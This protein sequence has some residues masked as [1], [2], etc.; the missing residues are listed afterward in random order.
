MGSIDENNIFGLLPAFVK[1]GDLYKKI[2]PGAPNGWPFQK[3]NR[4]IADLRY[5]GKDIIIPST[6]IVAPIKS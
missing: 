4:I 3:G 5:G 2:I 1:Q 6:L